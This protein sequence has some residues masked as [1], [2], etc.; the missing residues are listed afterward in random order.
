MKEFSP[1][2]EGLWWKPETCDEKYRSC[3]RPCAA[4]SHQEG[5]SCRPE[6]IKRVFA[7]V[8]APAVSTRREVKSLGLIMAG[9]NS[10][11]PPNIEV[12][13]LISPLLW[14]QHWGPWALSTISSCSAHAESHLGAPRNREEVRNTEC[15]CWGFVK[16]TCNRNSLFLSHLYRWKCNLASRMKYWF[17]V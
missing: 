10:L 1:S 17:L 15:A 14:S 7:P 12:G 4:S 6:W 2:S 16:G 5:R 8:Q 11:F 3:M 9:E 13:F